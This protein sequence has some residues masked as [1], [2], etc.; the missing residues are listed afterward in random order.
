MRKFA[1]IAHMSETTVLSETT[2]F[3]SRYFR[4]KH[5]TL[6][7]D[8][9]TFTKDII[10]RNQV[11]FILP[12]TQQNEVY[13]VSQYRDALHRTLL[14]IVAG[15]MTDG[16]DPLVAAQRELEEETGLTAKQWDKIATWELSANMSAPIHLFLARD[17]TEGDSHTDE[18]ED[19]SVVKM[20]LEEAVQKA[21][22]GKIEAASH[23][24]GIL[25][26][27]AILKEGNR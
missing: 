21:L 15:T 13:L 11:V 17:L 12:V 4:V 7:R 3:Q 6:K 24:G 22:D 1:M 23:V 20:P 26:L 18:D 19:L 14:E 5:V 25:F 9:K 27:N 10:E 8:G 16:E 2:T